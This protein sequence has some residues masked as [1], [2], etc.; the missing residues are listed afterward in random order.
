MSISETNE[1]YY[2]H[3]SEV[4][5]CEIE[6]L[7]LPILK[8]MTAKG[9]LIEIESDLL[10]FLKKSKPTEKSKIQEERIGVLSD[11]MD[12]FSKVASINHQ[13]KLMLRRAS[14]DL[15]KEKDAHKETNRVLDMLTNMINE[16]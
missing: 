5:L 13:M 9:V 10:K 8:I 15:Q 4:Y 11:V 7:E 12:Y 16:G 14:N 3:L 1:E 2:R 6:D